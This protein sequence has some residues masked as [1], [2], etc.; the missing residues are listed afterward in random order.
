M[1]IRSVGPYAEAE[2]LI[3]LEIRNGVT[4]VRQP[5]YS[6]IPE[7]L[8]FLAEG[9]VLRSYDMYRIKILDTAQIYIFGPY[10]PQ[11]VYTFFIPQRYLITYYIY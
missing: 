11:P 5:R 6:E 9:Y 1:I 7:A 10:R 2:R 4:L 8:I 3:S